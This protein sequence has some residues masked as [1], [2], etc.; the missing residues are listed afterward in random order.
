MHNY[1]LVWK[2]N[3]IEVINSFRYRSY[4]F[5]QET[6]L[7]YLNSRYY[8]PEFGRFI[9]ADEIL[10]ANED[11]LG[12]NLYAYVSDNPVNNYDPSGKFLLKIIKK[13]YDAYISTKTTT[14]ITTY[15][16]N[17]GN[18]PKS[19]TTN[20]TTKI[21]KAT[22]NYT[23]NKTTG[24]ISMDLTKSDAR[25][26]HSTVL[27]KEMLKVSNMSNR[28]VGGV[29]TELNGHYLGYMLL[30]PV[31]SLPVLGTLYGHFQDTNIGSPGPRSKGMDWN[32]STWEWLYQPIPMPKP[33]CMSPPK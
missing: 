9:N 25:P 1:N 2:S 20:V 33:I 27:A 18:Y 23:V 17:P 29:A 5:D 4:Y 16:T 32:A 13:I 10:G 28:T 15:N 6:G 24:D 26:L 30:K 14:T 19:N 8:S 3:N 22:Y 31:N 21:N 12:Y 7:Y 11:I